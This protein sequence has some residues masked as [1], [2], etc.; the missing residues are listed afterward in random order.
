MRD[1]DLDEDELDNEFNHWLISVSPEKP[2]PSRKLFTTT[3][4]ESYRPQQL[5]IRKPKFDEYGNEIED[6]GYRNP[7][8]GAGRPPSTNPA[9]KSISIRVTPFQH[10]KFL[11]LGASKWIKKIIDEASDQ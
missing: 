8:G 5:K 9:S 1:Y 2:A 7:G 4:E 3:E 10:Q 6:D 11:S